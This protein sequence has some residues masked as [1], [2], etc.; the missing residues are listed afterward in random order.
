MSDD[1]EGLSLSE[2]PAV[3]NKIIRRKLSFDKLLKNKYI[4]YSEEEL[5]RMNDSRKDDILDLDEKNKKLKEE[6]T[7]VIE[8]L[9]ILITS[10]SEILFQ[11]QQKNLTE[12]EKLEKIFYLRKH[13][14]TLSLKYNTTFK[15]QYTALKAK[16][17]NLGDQEK[18]ALKIMNDK[19]ILEKLKNENIDLNKKIQEQQFSN[20]KQTKELENSNFIQ[21]SENNIQNYANILNNSSL[22]R[23]D[24]HDKI[25]NK[26]K[27]VEQLKEQFNSLNEYIK[28]N[29]NK[30]AEND[31]DETAMNKINNDLE[32]LKRD[33]D[34]EVDDIIQSCY[35]N[36]ISLV[37][38]ENMKNNS[39]RSSKA[40]NSKGNTTNKHKTLQK[41]NPIKNISRSQ[42]SLYKLQSN[43]SDNYHSSTRKK[44][45]DTNGQKNYSIFSKFKILKSNKPL[46]IGV[47]SNA[48]PTKNISM[49]VTKE[50][51]DFSKKSPEEQEL[52]K[53]IKNID[54]NDFQKLIDLKGNYVD[55]NDRLVLDIKEKKKIS[56]NRIKQLSICIENNIAK[57]NQIKEANEIMKKELDEYEEK[58]MKNIKKEN[59]NKKEK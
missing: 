6:L 23:F 9:N 10:N 55:I 59:N 37:N 16:S 7:K 1:D 41:L 25:E 18:I 56:N 26:K 32:I 40:I 4:N 33:L 30:I 50:V 15:Q 22:L 5:I 8:K 44:S 45:L 46:K 11:D 47:S 19:N 35:D 49:F 13:D 20:I 53:E 54:Q 24:Y 14:H 27:S 39:L 3:K 12:I 52:E 17:K 34:K 51:I 21:K 38:E 58:M 48:K 42:S 2:M 36:Q 31:K 28:K 29:K 43:N 57:L